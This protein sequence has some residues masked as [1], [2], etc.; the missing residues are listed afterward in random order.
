MKKTTKK[1]CMELFHPHII[2]KNGKYTWN[3]EEHPHP[4][5]EKH[6]ALYRDMPIKPINKYSLFEQNKFLV[7][8]TTLFFMSVL[9][10]CF[11]LQDLRGKELPWSLVSGY[12][13]H[14]FRIGDLYL[15]AGKVWKIER[16]DGFVLMV[17]DMKDIFDCIY[18]AKDFKIEDNGDVKFR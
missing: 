8:D 12:K 7:P 3:L 11:G 18:F 5:S 14:T 1:D 10:G 6:L 17:E 4:T 2:L 9:W 16:R 15:K 13:R